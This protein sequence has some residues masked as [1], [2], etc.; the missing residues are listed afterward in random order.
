MIKTRVKLDKNSHGK[1][2]QH[3]KMSS[4]MLRASQILPSRHA[5]S[6]GACGRPRSGCRLQRR[7]R[8]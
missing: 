4:A 1:R 5:G 6:A 8:L 3:L 2:M 7:L